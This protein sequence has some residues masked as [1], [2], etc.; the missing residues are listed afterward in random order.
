MKDSIVIASAT[1]Q[2]TSRRAVRRLDC[3]VPPAHA[4]RFLAMTHGR[5]L[6]VALNWKAYLQ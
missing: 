5:L 1:K 4:R 3:S 6:S 2:S